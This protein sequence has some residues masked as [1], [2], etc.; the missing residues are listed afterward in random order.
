M[1]LEFIYVFNRQ[2]V[3]YLVIINFLLKLVIQGH[4]AFE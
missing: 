4:T 2:I 1:I 3:I